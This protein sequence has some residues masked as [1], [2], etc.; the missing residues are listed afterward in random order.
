VR[1]SADVL[2]LAAFAVI[3]HNPGFAVHRRVAGARSGRVV[4]QS[5]SISRLAATPWSGGH[6]AVN[7][8]LRKPIH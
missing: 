1:S 2:Q 5:E 7:W 4:G 3:T 8:A 6:L